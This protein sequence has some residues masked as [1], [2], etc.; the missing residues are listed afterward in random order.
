L[1]GTVSIRVFRVRFQVRN[2]DE[3]IESAMDFHSS[4]VE[5]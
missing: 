2:P 3:L 4:R 1:R 5:T